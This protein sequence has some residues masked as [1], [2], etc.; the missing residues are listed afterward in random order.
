[1]V[2]QSRPS[3]QSSGPSGGYVGKHAR[4]GSG[5]GSKAAAIPPPAKQ[6][7]FSSAGARD[8][9]SYAAIDL[10]TNNCRLL[11]AKPSADGFIV[12]D[13]FSRIVRLGEG[14]ASSGRISDAAIDRAIAALSRR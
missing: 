1:M 2:Q 3:P 13:A 9:R 14:L 7:G 8:R 11:I 5:N 4:S 6:R 12:V 10:G